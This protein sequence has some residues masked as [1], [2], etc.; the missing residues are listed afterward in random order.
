MWGGGGIIEKKIENDLGNETF[1]AS[2][3]WL[4][5]FRSWNNIVFGTMSGETG[6]A[7]E[8]RGTTGK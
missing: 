3:G 2:N 8:S 5:S 4:D 6:D 1:K 7:P